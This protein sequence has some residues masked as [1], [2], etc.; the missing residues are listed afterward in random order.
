LKSVQLLVQAGAKLNLPDGEGRTALQ[1]AQN[2]LAMGT[3]LTDQQKKDYAAIIK[4]LQPP[5]P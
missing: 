2:A 3:D 4:L 5:K 1:I